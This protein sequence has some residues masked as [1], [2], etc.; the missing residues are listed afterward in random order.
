M[1]VGRS[2]PPRL[3]SWAAAPRSAPFGER[4]HEGV[5]R[6]RELGSVGG[7]HSVCP[8]W[9]TGTRRGV[10]L[11]GICRSKPL[12]RS[13]TDGNPATGWSKG[14]AHSARFRHHC[15]KSK[16]S[17]RLCGCCRI[18]SCGKRLRVRTAF[19]ELGLFRH[20][21]FFAHIISGKKEPSPPVGWGTKEKGR[22]GLGVHIHKGER[23]NLTSKL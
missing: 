20:I 8:S 14:V 2:L 10:P 9:S 3:E 5:C 13:V 18:S 19:G 7:R 22:G 23:R 16:A 6:A 11:A 21:I 12:L 15:R 4:A 17:W 1:H